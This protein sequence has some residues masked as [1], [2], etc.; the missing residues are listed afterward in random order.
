MEARKPVRPS[1]CSP[2]LPF[3]QAMDVVFKERLACD[4]KQTALRFASQNLQAEH[5]AEHWFDDMA[6]VL[7]SPQACRCLIHNMCCPIPEPKHGGDDSHEGPGSTIFVA[8][9]PCAPF[10]AQRSSRQRWFEHPEA[11][12]MNQ[13]LKI[14]EKRLPGAGVLE[15]VMGVRHAG[16]NEKSA[17]DLII[18]NLTLAGYSAAPTTLCMSSFLSIARERTAIALACGSTAIVCR[19]IHLIYI[20][21]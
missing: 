8:G 3:A 21:A 14:I 13:T 1:L 9:F 20:Y 7:K 5:V 19:D 2:L 18:E 4:R 15:N 10:S 17:L 6:G 11:L 16:A 12:A